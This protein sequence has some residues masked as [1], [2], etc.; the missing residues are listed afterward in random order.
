MVLNRYPSWQESLQAAEGSRPAAAPTPEVAEH[1]PDNLTAEI[2]PPKTKY[3][4][5]HNRFT[6]FCN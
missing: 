3:K 6:V 5:K 1:F 4:F 2:V